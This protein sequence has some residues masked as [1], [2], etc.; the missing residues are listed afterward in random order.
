M[1]KKDLDLEATEPL[2]NAPA[3]KPFERKAMSKV[4]ATRTEARKDLSLKFKKIFEENDPKNLKIK[5]KFLSKVYLHVICQALLLLLMIFLAFKLEVFHNFLFRN[6]VALYI[7]LIL[8]FVV[9][10]RPLVS[11]K[12]LKK[13]PVNYFYIFF[14]TL[15]FG[16]ILCR[17]AI[18]FQYPL[19]LIFI[20]LYIVEL[21]YLLIESL[22]QNNNEKKETDI[23]NTATF[24]GLFILFAGAILCFI[25]QIKI[26]KLLIIVLM[27][28]FL[29][30]YIIYDMNCILINKRRLI[31]KD[32]YALAT[33]F[34]YIDIF[35]TFLELMEKFYSSCEPERKPIKKQAHKKN[36]IFTGEKEYLDRY[37]DEEDEEKKDN[38][39]DEYLYLKKHERRKSSTD[40]K[41]T[42]INVD[43]KAPILEE[44]E[45]DYISD[46]DENNT[47]NNINR[48][49]L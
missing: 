45:N 23:A 21:I 20:I 40:L 2:L 39:D 32:E 33:M 10:I 31:N 49:S 30:V 28:V 8:L 42:M 47:S 27:I 17:I 44:D 9:L 13:F 14:F 25:M 3:I 26:L 6:N 1:E 7:A 46:K 22:I 15:C 24:M 29:G 16:Y 19:V 36:M 4:S 41:R 48:K 11:D 18:C 12:V 5:N 35:Q 38:D 34:L 43:N 37:R